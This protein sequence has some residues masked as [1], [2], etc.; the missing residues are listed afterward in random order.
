MKGPAILSE[1]VSYQRLRVM[2]R[3]ESCGIVERVEK[4]ASARDF[5]Y[6]GRWAHPMGLAPMVSAKGLVL[7]IESLTR[8]L[9]R[10]QMRA[11]DLCRTDYRGFAG[12][13]RLEKGT[14]RWFDVTVGVVPRPWPLLTR[15]DYALGIRDGVLRPALFELN[16]LMLGGLYIQSVALELMN[17][18][19]L[20]GI[21]RT[22]KRLGITPMVDLIAYFQRWIAACR[23]RAGAGAGCLA[24][25]E[26][27]PPGGGFSE[28]PRIA[29]RLRRAG[30]RV[31]HGDPKSLEVRRGRVFL[32]GMPVAYAYR[33]FSFE[34]VS[35]PASPSMRGFATLWREGRAAPGFPADFDQK[36]ILECLSS[37]EFAPLFTRAEARALAR[38]VPWTRVLSERRTLSQ[39]GR[40]VDLP[41]H[42]LRRQEGLVIKPSWSAGGEG[43]L[44]GR[45]T[46]AAKWRKAVEGA[47]QDPGAYAVQSYVDNPAVACAYLR[48]GKVHFKDCRYT[49]GAFFDGSRF[50]F[51]LRVSPG[52]IV[53]VAQGG[54]LAP[55]YL[56]R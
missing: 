50:G 12:L 33:D 11:P 29:S 4:A 23:R 7:A 54:A 51:H 15:P 43:I 3:E 17:G 13:I 35:G 45:H 8:V 40:G 21:S 39:E 22:P 26:S 18:L 16:S 14:R 2:A 5:H 28:L 20:P 44:I 48:E 55:L 56:P 9:F 49:L 36:G 52:H 53:N 46:A 24:L 31:E 1:P 6:K 34:D 25:L 19:V 32:N 42:V 38:H 47:L 30:L 41:A 37:E 10:F 27:L